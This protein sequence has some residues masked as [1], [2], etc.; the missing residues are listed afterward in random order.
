MACL[1]FSKAN[2]QPRRLPAA[3]WSVLVFAMLC[4]VGCQQLAIPVATGSGSL[5]LQGS[6]HGGQQGISG[7]AIELYAVGT[8]GDG[9]SAIPLLTKPVLT[10]AAGGFSLHGLYTCPTANSTVYVVARGGNPGLPAGTT[11]DAI[12]LMALLGPCGAISA[13][14]PINV[15][16]VTTVGALWP[17]ARFTNSASRIGFTLGDPAFA[18][19][20]ETAQQL[21]D[22]TTG[23]SPGAAVPDGYLVPSNK[24]NTLANILA[25]CVNSSGGATGDGSPCGTLFSLATLAGFDP[26]TDTI[27]AALHIARTPTRNVAALLYLA[28]ISPPFQPTLTSAPTDWTLD[29]QLKMAAPTILPAAGSYA[30]GQQIT[31]SSSSVDGV[32]HYTLNGTIP[33]AASAVYSSPLTLTA[34]ETVRAVT[35]GDSGSS[36]TS[37]V[38]YSVGAPHLV[39]VTQP[40]TIA[41]GATF[42]P[43]PVVQI[44]DASGALMSGA[45][46]TVTLSLSRADGSSVA[47]SGGTSASAVGG[48]AIFPG[49]SIDD[50]G[51]GYVLE[52]N[53]PGLGVQ[54]SHAFNVM[55]SAVGTQTAV[56][57][58]AIPASFFGMSVNHPATPAPSL[59]FGTTRS[60]DA[61]GLAWADL[62]PANGTY[63]FAAL[64][65]FIAKNQAR[66]AQVIYTFGRTPQWASAQPNAPGSYAPG[67]CAPPLNLS[68]WDSYVR[69]IVTH[70]AGKIKYWEIWNE[71]NNPGFYCGQVSTMITLAQHASAIIKSIDPTA[72][73]LSPALTST[74]GPQWLGWYLSGGGGAVVDVIAFHGYS[75]TDPQ[76]I[77]QVVANYRGVMAANGA[78]GKPMWNTETSWAGD[79]DLV[80]PD[81][82]H[83]VAFVS[84]AYLLQWS[85]GVSRVLWYAYDGG[86]I[87]GGLWDPTAGASAAAVAY[88]EAY[89]WMVNAALSQPCAVDQTGT[90]TC[91]LARSGGYVAEAIWRPNASATVTVPAQFTEYRDLAGNIHAISSGAVVIGNQPI[92]LE[93]GPLPQ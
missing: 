65:T 53:A 68:A 90:W 51:I 87:W 71:P 46:P 76:D 80:T 47:L 70:V 38:S 1:P 54:Q 89:R 73:V 58:P 59:P 36:E 82:A 74:S 69:A 8:S 79:G 91:G 86:T 35:L 41:N 50:S 28:P 30:T 24:L 6:V 32:I 20:I 77:V 52:A 40:H 57:G 92:L 72:L 21:A 16:E 48:M 43:A 64:D 11:N 56:L 88:G 85:L 39:F 23:L 3:L 81:M 13:T 42:V 14:T 4:T 66:G 25:A 44:V 93:S 7:S 49:L 22:T 10:D 33:S 12:A 17:M 67:Q 84:K 18:D 19:A 75:T 27:T 29:L 61:D 31:L 5:S 34:A 60:W 45:S 26:V 63:N 83:Q 37:T 78:A 55:S 15:N 9:S 2:P 62:N